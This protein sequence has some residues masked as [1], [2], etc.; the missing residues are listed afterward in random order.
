MK[1]AYLGPINSYSFLAAKILSPD[2]ELVPFSDFEPVLSALKNG[3]DR[4]VVPIENSTE[5][6]VS[7]ALDRILE[8]D[9]IYIVKEYILPVRHSLICRPDCSL[10]SIRQILTHY[11]AYSQCRDYIKRNYPL[12]EVVLVSS[13]SKA[14][15]MLDANSLAIAG[16]SAATG[17]KIIATDIQD[18]PDNST[19]FW[20]LS[21]SADYFFEAKKLSIAFEAEHKPGGLL[22]ILNIIND[23]SFNMTRIESRPQKHENWRYKFIVDIEAILTD[24]KA[25]EMIKDLGG[26]T[27]YLRILGNY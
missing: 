13:T 15:E 6:S 22:K 19:R 2:S 3:C 7:A 16:A 14:V 11:Q 1:T 21:N 17:K 20:L 10:E 23:Y 4:A 26:S 24:P 12:A 9:N 5:G 27:T 25:K 8:T 18:K